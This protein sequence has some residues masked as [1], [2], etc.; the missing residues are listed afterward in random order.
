M[1]DVYSDAGLS[2]VDALRELPLEQLKLETHDL[3]VSALGSLPHLR[4]LEL[5]GSRMTGVDRL[6]EQVGLSA[7]VD[8]RWH[9][10]IAAPFWHDWVPPESETPPESR[11]IAGAKL[12]PDAPPSAC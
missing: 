12:W 5:G 11:P 3:D 9:S 7:S 6:P 10:V 8:S 4:L 2:D 1:L